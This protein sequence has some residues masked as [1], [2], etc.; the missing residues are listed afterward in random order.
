MEITD[1]FKII[2]KRFLLIIAAGIFG[3]LLGFLVA[4]ITP[5]KYVASATIAVSKKVEPSKD[6]SFSYEGYYAGQTADKF[7]ET[8]FGILKSKSLASETLTK[9]NYPVNFKTLKNFLG[10]VFVRKS[11]PSLLYLEV[12]GGT[13]AEAKSFAEGLISSLNEEVFRIF[14]EQSGLSVSL[15]SGK[16]VLERVESSLILNMIIGSIIGFGISLAFAI[17]RK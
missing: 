1:I 10:A 12:K 5:A 4:E 17:L 3:G 15:I 13:E 16:P 8:V 11:A 14:D 2:Q 7:S 6:G 9:L